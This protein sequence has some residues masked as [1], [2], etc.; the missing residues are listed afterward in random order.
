MRGKSSFFKISPRSWLAKILLVAI[1]PLWSE[2]AAA[3]VCPGLVGADSPADRDRPVR[4]LAPSAADPR[5]AVPTAYFKKNESRLAF[6]ECYQNRQGREREDLIVYLN[7]VRRMDSC[8]AWFSSTSW[9]KRDDLWLASCKSLRSFSLSR[10]AC[11]TV[12]LK[13]I[14]R[15]KHT[16]GH[17]KPMRGREKEQN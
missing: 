6:I 1:L 3:A 9:A 5:A 10:L 2:A 14:V 12:S 4:P 11:S 17:E 8:L 15:S 16:R 13:T 7:C